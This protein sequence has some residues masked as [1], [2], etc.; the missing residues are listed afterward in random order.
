MLFHS[1]IEILLEKLYWVE[2]AEGENKFKS[3]HVEANEFTYHV[4]W[5]KQNIYSSF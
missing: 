5:K 3:F 4:Y 2:N 1:S